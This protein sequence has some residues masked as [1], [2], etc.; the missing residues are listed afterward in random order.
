MVTKEMIKELREK[1]GAGLVDC[2]KALQ[3][4]NGDI[5]ESIKILREKGLA[6]AAKRAERTA[7]QGSI[8]IEVSGAQGAMVELNCETDF[9]AKTDEFQNTAK[10]IVQLAI[11]NNTSD[12]DSLLQVGV[13]SANN[14]SVSEWIK[15]KIGVIGENI[16]LR[17]VALMK[18]GDT[19]YI[20]QYIHGNGNIGVMAQF[21]TG[22]T[23]THAKQEFL[24][25]V[26]GV[27]MHIAAVNPA[28]LDRESVDP[29][30]LDKE[31][32]I[33]RKQ[34]LEQGKPENIVDKIVEGKMNKYYEEVCLLEQE[35]VVL[36]DKQKVN[37]VLKDVG[38]ATG[39]QIN[40]VQFKRFELGA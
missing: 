20:A 24:D 21:S 1:S 14:V 25:L 31:K 36:E 32:A 35:Y 38:K 23:D 37:Q 29:A 34:M 26:N 27:C 3:E 40:L 4:T 5:E 33:Y 28:Y 13:P 6:S 39:D 12:V 30:E 17:N 8:Q 10:E 22:N 19:D 18:A 2:K 16:V 7:S 9:V 15:Q 11:N